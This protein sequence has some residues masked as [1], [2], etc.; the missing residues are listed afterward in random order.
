MDSSRSLRYGVAV[1]PS[2]RRVGIPHGPLEGD[3]GDVV[4]FI[5]DHKSV[6]SG[7]L[8][9]ILSSGEGLRHGDVHHPARSA[10]P[11]DLADLLLS[12][13]EMV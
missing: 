3:R 5:Y 4:A 1:R 2:H 9:E 10:L 8:G 12:Q 13:A 11:A 6:A 7:Y